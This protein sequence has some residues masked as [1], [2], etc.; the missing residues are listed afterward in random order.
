[1]TTA[2]PLRIGI[3]GA[4]GIVKQRHMPGLRSLEGIQITAVANARPASAEAF[5]REFA[6]EARVFSRWEDVVDNEE[7]D[8]VWVGA[9][10]VLHHDAVCFSL[11]CGKHVFTQAR[12]AATLAEAERMWEAAIRFPELVTAI[13]PAPHGMKNGAMVMKLLEEGAIGQPLHAVLHSLNAAWLDAAQPAHWRQKIEISGI[14]ILT[15][16]IYLEVIQRW[17]G[18]VVEVAAHGRVVIP[19]RQGYEVQTPDY[20]NVLARFRSGL[21][22]VLMFSGV[23]AHAP[24]DKLYLYGSEGMLSYEFTTDGI[25]LGRPGAALAAVP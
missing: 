18:H 13:C 16:G 20:V 17:L 4:G 8:I 2:T 22:A 5:C 10:P 14:Q 3:V 9:P 1:M 12:M 7:V 21:E 19:Q 23:A 25:S 15:L 6:P 11:E 24:G